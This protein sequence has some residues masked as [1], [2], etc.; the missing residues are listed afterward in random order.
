MV[1]RVVGW[2]GSALA[3]GIAAHTIHNLRG[4]RR[5][6]P[7]AGPVTESVA[8]LIPA[9]NEQATIDQCL[10]A[11]TAQV[12]VPD[13]QIRVLDD[14]STDGTAQRVAA[15]VDRDRRVGLMR[16]APTPPGWGGKNFACAQLA[17]TTAADVLV[18]VDADVR[19][20]P[21]AVARA[22][23]QLRAEQVAVVSPFPRQLAVTWA[24]RLVQPLLIWSIVALLP[25]RRALRSLRP[26][27]AVANGQFIVVAAAAYRAAGGHGAARAAVLDDIELVRSVQ[28]AGFCGGVTDGS[29][30]ASCR[31]YQD[32]GQ[33]R[34][35]YTKSLWSA[36]GSGPGAV[37]VAGLLTG[38]FVVPAVAAAAG[39]KV[40]WCGVVAGWLSR[41]VVAR[42]VGTQLWPDVLTHPVAVAGFVGLLADSWRGRW[43]GS[44]RWRGR[45]VLV[46]AGS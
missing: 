20:A 14:E 27:L 15:W 3:V 6:E 21:D 1:V 32:A 25:V 28:R 10:A 29:T 9:R 37:A 42:R 41:A 8:V 17:D 44:L 4:F 43:R 19:L 12:A 11:V 46:D 30:I 45:P 31:M 5:P 38:A 23:Q 16:G 2:V 13:L 34:A 39:S 40:A 18:F 33:V 36:F 22:V 7:V 35:G 24:E 26:S